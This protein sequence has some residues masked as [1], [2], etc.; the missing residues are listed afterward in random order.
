M[1]N[2][3]SLDNVKTL[4]ILMK[5]YGSSSDMTPFFI[6]IA[7]HSFEILKEECKND[8]KE[9]I[10]GL[11]GPMGQGFSIEVMKETGIYDA[12]FNQPL[13]DMFLG[14][15]SKEDWRAIIAAWRLKI[16]I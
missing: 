14:I 13:E 11:W 7:Q 2:T 6:E 8:P 12:I 4:A 1:E 5:T 15:G 3:Y 16:G 10:L 9:I